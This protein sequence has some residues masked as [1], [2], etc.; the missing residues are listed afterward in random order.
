MIF[1]NLF[2]I[3][4]VDNDFFLKLCFFRIIILGMF[5]RLEVLDLKENSLLGLCFFSKFFWDFNIVVVFVICC[6]SFF[7]WV[8]IWLIFKVFR[9]LI[10]CRW[11]L[12][13]FFIVFNIFFFLIFILLIRL[14]YFCL[15]FFNFVFI[16]FI[17]FFS[18]WMW[19]LMLFFFF[20]M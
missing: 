14:L 8:W 18:S 15:F 10:F 12:V 3:I 17:C 4:F 20:M 11:L 9:L 13:V 16:I 7:F 6:L 5:L 1:L 2:L 19:F